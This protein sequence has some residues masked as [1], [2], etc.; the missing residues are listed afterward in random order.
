MEIHD[1][2]EGNALGY[3]KSSADVKN[4]NVKRLKKKK[5]KINATSGS[6]NTAS[7]IVTPQPSNTDTANEEFFDAHESLHSMPGREYAY[8]PLLLFQ[9]NSLGMKE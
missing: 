8:F 2:K 9:G 1:I 3:T 6:T 4:G 7:D 5:R